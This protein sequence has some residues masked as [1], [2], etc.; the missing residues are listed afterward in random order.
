MAAFDIMAEAARAAE[1]AVQ[2]RHRIHRRPE[3]GNHETQTSALVEE[4]LDGLGIEVAR[5]A[6]T[7]VVGLLRGERPGKTIALRA[8]MDA[9]PLSEATGLEYASEVPGVMHACG[10][11]MHTAGLLGAAMV[12]ARHRDALS[13]NV[14]L[15]FQPDEEGDG[16]AL[17]MIEA[18]CLEN[19]HVDAAF[20]AHVF[21]GLPAGTVGLRYGKAYAASDMFTVTIRGRSCHGASPN[22]GIDAVAIGAQVVTALQQIVSRR[23]SPLDSAVVTIGAFHAG[24]AGNI[25]ADTAEL[26]GILRTLGREA[27]LDVRQWFADTVTGVC[28]ALGANADVC[29][30]PSYPGIVNHDE[31]VEFLR[32]TAIALLG[33]EHV[34]TL[35]RPSMGT[36][37]FGYFIENTPGCFWQ[38]GVRGEQ[39]GSAEPLHSVRFAP[40]ESSLTTL[41][42]MHTA[43][44]LAYSGT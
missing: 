37:D 33:S 2:L 23:V 18:G 6:G 35:D 21:P 22:N 25:I 17:R 4:T 30:I 39:P 16:G 20:G 31:S 32:R 3:L 24:S 41:I 13:G 27:R 7:S 5:P 11:D 36:E 42:A 29:I 43:V 1:T 19:P 44:A 9:L 28:K 15:L 26:K 14:K 38:V 34:V 10:H 40:D 12:L 8:D